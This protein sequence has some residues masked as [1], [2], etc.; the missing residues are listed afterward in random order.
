MGV[1]QLL[2]FPR[3]L[4]QPLD[5]STTVSDTVINIPASPLPYF[6]DAHLGQVFL[7]AGSSLLGQS[8]GGA[9]K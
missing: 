1:L 9:T 7:C 8:H 5:F 3:Y 2:Q 6:G 4:K